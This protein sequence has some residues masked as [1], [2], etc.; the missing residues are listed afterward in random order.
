MAMI[1]ILFK[2][3]THK[4]REKARDM[5]ITAIYIFF[6]ETDCLV[7]PLCL[8]RHENEW[9]QQCGG[10]RRKT[11]AKMR[12]HKNYKEKTGIKCTNLQLMEIS[13]VAV[14][15]TAAVPGV[16]CEFILV[17]QPA[18]LELG[19]K[20]W[21]TSCSGATAQEEEEQRTTRQHIHRQAQNVFFSREKENKVDREK[22]GESKGEKIPLANVIHLGS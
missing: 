4:N 13:T 12:K 9:G 2:P 21:D 22:V 15:S 6:G 20:R 8:T 16:N 18:P 3:S 1:Y 19:W 7:Q 5:N 17:S 14:G 10:T 11:R